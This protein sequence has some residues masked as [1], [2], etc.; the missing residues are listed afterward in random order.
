V[1]KQL[2]IISSA[3]SG[4]HFYGEICSRQN[5]TTK[6]NGE[7]LEIKDFSGIAQIVQPR[8]KYKLLTS[9]KYVLENKTIHILRRRDK[10]E[11][12]RSWLFYDVTGKH[13][14]AVYNQPLPSI[15]ISETQIQE[16]ISEQI[17]DYSFVHDEIIYYEDL[18]ETYNITFKK[19]KKNIYNIDMKT[20]VT[21]WNDVEYELGLFKYHE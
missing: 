1:V 20:F 8:L 4:S 10:I 12:F 16:F 18:L 13:N 3:R 11:Q 9:Q 15:T 7:L 2:V 14:G 17:F 19:M 6:Y 5:P 21:N